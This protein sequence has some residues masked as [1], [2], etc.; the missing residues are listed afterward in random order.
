MVERTEPTL[1]PAA[2]RGKRHR[3]ELLLVGQGQAVLH[4]LVQHLLTL[5]GAPARTVA[6]DHVLRWEAEAARQNS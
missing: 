4:R 3:L 2:N 5:V 6:V 1:P